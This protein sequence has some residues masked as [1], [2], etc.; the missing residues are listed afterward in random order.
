[1]DETVTYALRVVKTKNEQHAIFFSL[2]SIIIENVVLWLYHTLWLMNLT[3]VNIVKEN[4]PLFV[5]EVKHWPCADWI[6]GY[7]CGRSW[8][9]VKLKTKHLN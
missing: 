9:R 5:N 6:Y 8:V 7:E 4:V 3:N 2:T 1:M